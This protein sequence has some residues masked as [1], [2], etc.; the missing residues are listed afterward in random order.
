[1]TATPASLQPRAGGTA[2]PQVLHVVTAGDL[3]EDRLAGPATG[4]DDPADD[5]SAGGTTGRTAIAPSGKGTTAQAATGPAQMSGREPAGPR[6]ATSTGPGV[7]A[8][9]AVPR[10]VLLRARLAYA[11]GRLGPVGW[12]GL[13]A[14]AI[15]L[16]LGVA[17]LQLGAVRS[18]EA[19]EASSLSA[20]LALVRASRPVADAGA[21]LDAA[22]VQVNEQSDPIGAV[23]AQLPAAAELMP[24]VS[25]VQALAARNAVRIDRTEYRVQP[26]LGNRAL[27]YQLVLPAH[28]TYPRVRGWLDALLLAYPTATL[29]EL[30]VQ[31]A[32]EGGGIDARIAIGYFTRSA[33]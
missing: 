2:A 24:F 26:A 5:A 8:R 15:G 20:R 3:A 22:G 17:A 12:V 16:A 13:G 6:A 28:G 29:D 7:P 33:R 30:Q 4:A 9:P 31:R 25:T 23:V 32:A 19:L 27:R 11:V 21:P 10:V 14:G 18:D 1:V